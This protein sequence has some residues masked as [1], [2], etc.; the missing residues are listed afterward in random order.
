MAIASLIVHVESGRTAHVVEELARMPGVTVHGQGDEI[1][2]VVVVER[3]SRE[4]DDAEKEIRAI[5]GALS[6]SAVYLNLEDEL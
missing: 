3:P 2:L 6:V 1:S 4:M 5:R